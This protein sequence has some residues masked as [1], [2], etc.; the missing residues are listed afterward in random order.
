MRE[1]ERKNA[2]KSEK[3]HGTVYCESVEI[4]TFIGVFGGFCDKK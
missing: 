4:P 2:K 3:T 1:I